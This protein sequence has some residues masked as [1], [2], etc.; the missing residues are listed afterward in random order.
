MKPMSNEVVTVEEKIRSAFM[1]PWRL[2]S[3]SGPDT[4]THRERLLHAWNRKK[5]APQHT[6]NRTGDHSLNYANA[7][8]Q[9]CDNRRD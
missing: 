3:T 6:E 9:Q 4:K 1:L 8:H 2:Q 5:S 7:R